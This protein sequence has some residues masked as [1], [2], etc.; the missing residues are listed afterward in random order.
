MDKGGAKALGFPFLFFT[1]GSD[2]FVVQDWEMKRQA[3]EKA[4]IQPKS[5]LAAFAVQSLPEQSIQPKGSTV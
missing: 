2:I 4:Q 5:I 3:S 1:G